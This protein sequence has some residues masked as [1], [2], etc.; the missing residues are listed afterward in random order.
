MVDIPNNATTTAVIDG[1][2]TGGSF[3]GEIEA[4]GDTDWIRVTLTAGVTYRFYAHAI[5][6][7]ANDSTIA[8]WHPNGTQLIQDDDAGTGSDS[9]VQYTAVTSG[10]YDTEAGS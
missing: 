8:L 4:F 6:A 9:F 3:S 7:V 2:A 10:V 5:G 1:D